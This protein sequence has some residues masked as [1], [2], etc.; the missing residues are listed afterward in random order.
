MNLPQILTTTERSLTRKGAANFLT[1]LGFPI[2]AKTLRNMASNA[3]AGGGPAFYK[4]DWRSV[5]YRQ[6]DL[7]AWV[8]DK[9]KRIE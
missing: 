7:I 3:N 8:A 4:T 6:D 1:K 2:S 9:V 5:Y